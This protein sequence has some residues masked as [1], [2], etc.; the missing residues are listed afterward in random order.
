[1]NDEC[2]RIVFEDFAF[3]MAMATSSGQFI[4][5][6]KAYCQYL[7][8]SRLE[9]LGKSVFE[10][11][12]P[13]DLAHAKALFRE[14]ADGIRTQFRYKKRYFRKDGQEIQAQVTTAW[15]IESHLPHPICIATIQDTTCKDSPEIAVEEIDHIYR[16]L[17]ENIDL[18]ITL[19]NDEH[20]ILHLNRA[21]ARMYQKESRE[22][23][24]E[25]CF[26]VFGKQK[27]I[28]PYCPGTRAMKEGVSHTVETEKVRA[29]GS[30]FF[31]NIQAIPVFDAD[32]K[33]RKFIEVVEDIT[34]KRAIEWEL[35]LH[36]DKINYLAHHDS[37]TGLPNRTLLFDRLHLAIDRAQRD[38]EELA[39]II[40][41]L[42]GFKKICEILG[43]EVSKQ[44]LMEVGHRL[45]T[46]LRKMDNLCFM[47]GDEFG[48]VLNKAGI[49]Q[50]SSTVARK[51]LTG[52]KSRPFVVCGHELHITA[53]VGI[54]HYPGDGQDVETL[55]QAAEWARIRASEDGGDG[56]QYYQPAMERRS[57]HSL[58]LQGELHRALEEGQ[59]TAFY[60]A[61][62]DSVTGKIHGIE[63]LVRWLHPAKGIVSPNE[64]IPLAEE[65][66]LIVPLGRRVLE[67]VC[68]QAKKWHD[69]GLLH[70][71][72]AVNI[73]PL[74]IA[75]GNL[76][77]T[78]Q[79]VLIETGLPPD[80]LEIEIT[81]SALVKQPEKALKTLIALKN[82]GIR[83]A[84]DDFGTGYSA[85]SYLKTF[86]FDRI[87]IAQ[88]FI[89][90]V[91][92]SEHDAA[93]VES[94]FAL[95]KKLRMDVIAEGVETAEI[96]S[97]L[98]ALGCTV[99]QGYYFAK[100]LDAETITRH[101]KVWCGAYAVC[102]LM[103]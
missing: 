60:Q 51:I 76:E 99:V 29:D 63:A 8:Y 25:K 83:L 35:K 12:H 50:H 22:F 46:H 41:E 14:V 28:C 36:Q 96:L 38:N 91:R 20:R 93:I 7:G 39:V 49:L 92:I 95:G 53:S 58:K 24:G 19:I 48:M 23:L 32:G 11:T 102:P 61:Q 66:G 79:E 42:D 62:V 43:F 52:L 67:V 85:L 72:V 47:G 90:N 88:D 70:F 80:R 4:E 89:R 94:I 10:I 71:R 17:M 18:G 31:V 26:R 40:F 77:K 44:L 84:L 64:F 54:S 5:V 16:S 103:A 101:L 100:P 86:P 68:S 78:V 45:K 2:F 73:S 59:L 21:L 65:T 33:A 69:A 15:I 1:V 3:P 55:L 56:Y 81:E 87:K 9:L 13:G 57:Q 74:Q 98:L 37:L 34:A 27:D 6:N 30:R 82:M 97:C 75:R